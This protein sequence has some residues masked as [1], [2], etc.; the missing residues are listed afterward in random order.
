MADLTVDLLVDCRF[1]SIAYRQ[2]NMPAFTRQGLPVLFAQTQQRAHTQASTWPDHQCRPRGVGLAGAHLA[3]LAFAQTRHAQ[4]HRGEIIDQQQSL[5]LQGLAKCR[6]A[7][8]PV[9]VGEAKFIAIDRAGH[10][11]AHRRQATAG[12]TL[13][14]QVGSM[15]CSGLV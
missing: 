11:Q 1:A 12:D 2:V 6:A 7:Q 9:V 3:E 8:A 4:R 10:R 5:D 15:A 14:F 13:A